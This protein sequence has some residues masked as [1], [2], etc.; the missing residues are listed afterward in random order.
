MIGSGGM[1]AVFR[2]HDT[3]LHRTVAIKVVPSG[4]LSPHFH[5]I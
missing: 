4:G 1:G 2:A 5:S 3:R